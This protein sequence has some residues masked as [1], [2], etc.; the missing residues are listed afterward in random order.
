MG[1]LSAKAL[2]FTYYCRLFQPCS[3]DQFFL[4]GDNRRNQLGNCYVF[5]LLPAIN[6]GV[7]DAGWLDPVKVCLAAQT[8]TPYFYGFKIIIYGV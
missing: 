4:R 8:I 1:V 5:F 3:I 6:A 7:H 2:F